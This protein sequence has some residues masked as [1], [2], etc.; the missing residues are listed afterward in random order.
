MDSPF[1]HIVHFVIP[2]VLNIGHIAAVIAL[3]LTLFFT[4]RGRWLPA[5]RERD[6]ATWYRRRA[7]EAALFLSSVAILSDAM[8]VGSVGWS[9]GNGIVFLPLAAPI[10]VL[11]C[12]TMAVLFRQFG[13]SLGIPDWTSRAR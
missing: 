9:G 13:R 12:V 1:G 2:A 10:I 6:R 5:G 8:I 7:T 4:I 11:A 3:C